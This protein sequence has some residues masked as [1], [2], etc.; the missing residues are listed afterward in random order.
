MTRCASQLFPASI[1]F[2]AENE[3]ATRVFQSLGNLSTRAMAFFCAV[4]ITG[5][6]QIGL[7]RAVSSR[8][9][10]RSSG[11]CRAR[12][13]G[14]RNLHGF[15][16]SLRMDCREWIAKIRRDWKTKQKASQNLQ[17]QPFKPKKS[18]NIA[19]GLFVRSS[20][21]MMS[22][23]SVTSSQKA[24]AGHDYGSHSKPYNG[25]FIKFN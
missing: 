19:L 25:C 6:L 8:E 23:K 21:T 7:S 13:F 15:Q 2:E 17:G 20:W 22:K 4:A 3:P 5:T 18:L 11:L 12:S 9:P 16:R 1:Q 24:D 14:R 10:Q